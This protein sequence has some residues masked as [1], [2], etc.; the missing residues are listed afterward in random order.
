MGKKISR[1]KQLEEKYNISI[2]RINVE[3]YLVFEYFSNLEKT[4]DLYISSCGY[5]LETLN[6]LEKNVIEE[7][8]YLLECINSMKEDIKEEFYNEK[9][10]QELLK[11]FYETYP[12]MEAHND[13]TQI[14]K[15]D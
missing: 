11:R 6:E 3:G 7:L 4:D 8:E 5:W 12:S 13:K 9:E 10:Q 15:R 14:I 2:R 1:T